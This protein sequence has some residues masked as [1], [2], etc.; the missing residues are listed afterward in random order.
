MLFGLDLLAGED[1]FDDALLVDDEGGTDGAHGLLAIH[2]LLAPGAHG[3]EQGVVDI[4]YQGEGQFV[5]FLEL[6]MRGGRVFADAN[7]LVTSLLQ[8]LMMVTQTTSLSRT[9]T[10]IVLGI[11]IK[12]QF[13]ALEIAQ[14]DLIAILV[15]TQNL[16]CFVSNVHK[17][18]VVLIIWNE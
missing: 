16:G 3:L 5:L 11:E 4:S 18:I 17:L 9:T 15:L 7:N 14:T 6:N 1:L 12:N 13:S 10:G 8:C 2:G